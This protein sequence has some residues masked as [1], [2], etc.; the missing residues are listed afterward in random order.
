MLHCPANVTFI[1]PFLH[2]NFPKMNIL[3]AC[4]HVNE[5]FVG[6]EAVITRDNM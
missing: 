3:K 2:V 4:L 6:Q 5:S 1:T